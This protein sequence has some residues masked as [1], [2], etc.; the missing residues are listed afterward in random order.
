MMSEPEKVIF[1][2]KYCHL[3]R[4]G[5]TPATFV[6][7]RGKWM[8]WKGMGFVFVFF[9]VVFFVTMP[10]AWREASLGKVGGADAN[11]GQL[12]CGR[13]GPLTVSSIFYWRFLWIVH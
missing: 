8:D 5:R 7:L 13:L 12:H 10:A 4:Q 1:L 9:V 6:Q 11:V 3:S 2:S